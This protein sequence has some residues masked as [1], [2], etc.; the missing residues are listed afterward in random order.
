MNPSQATHPQLIAGDPQCHRATFTRFILPFKW[1]LSSCKNFDRSKPFFR[2]ATKDD[3]LHAA[4]ETQSFDKPHLDLPRQRYVTKETSSLLFANASWFV[5]NTAQNLK[6]FQVESDLRNQPYTVALRAP[7]LVLFECPPESHGKRRRINIGDDLLQNGFLIHEAYFP[8]TAP[9]YADFL[10][11]NEIFRYWRLPFP[12]YE[13][14]CKKELTSIAKG[15]TEVTGCNQ[16]TSY[17]SAQWEELLVLP[18]ELKSGTAAFF[19]ERSAKQATTPDYMINP[20]DRAFTMPFAVVNSGTPAQEANPLCSSF[21][22]AA[23]TIPRSSSPGYWV[24]L[25]NVDRPKLDGVDKLALASDFEIKWADR[26]TYK[27]WA[28]ASTLYGFCEHAFAAMVPAETEGD[29]IPFALHFGKMYF[30][31]TLLLLYLRVSVMRFSQELHTI[32]RTAE[33]KRKPHR[34]IE[35]WRKCFHTIRWQFLLLENLYQF[36]HLSNQQQ[37]IEMYEKQRKWMDIQDLYAQIDKEVRTSDEFLNAEVDEKRSESAGVLNI[38]AIVGL[39]L[40]IALAC[41]QFDGCKKVLEQ[42]RSQALPKVEGGGCWGGIIE[43]LFPVFVLAILC[44]G[45]LWGIALLVTWYKRR[46]TDHGKNF[47]KNKK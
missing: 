12:E 8:E 39:G 47:Q 46:H 34:E 36:P 26:R 6:P 7:A 2:P 4:T 16:N 35:Q 22:T 9:S 33:N 29:D 31:V 37:H 17:Y 44:V 1:K 5:L 3:W 23:T 14:W 25:L 30:D 28:H 40:S 21:L 43:N 42:L 15:V 18:V 11:F 32:T 38:V 10:R 13:K 20:D 45:S 24:K 41:Y 19:I 27:R